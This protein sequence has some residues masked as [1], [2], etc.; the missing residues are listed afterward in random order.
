LIRINLVSCLR[1]SKTT[2]H[3][4]P[5]ILKQRKDL[6]KD[7][8][9]FHENVPFLLDDSL[10]PHSP[11]T[12]PEDDLDEECVDNNSSGLSECEEDADDDE[13]CDDEDAPLGSHPETAYLP[14]PS[15]LGPDHFKN[16]LI[17]A[18]AAEEVQLHINQASDA[19]QQLRLSLGLKSA[20]LRSTVSVAKSQYT[21]T[22]A[23]RAVNVVDVS[24]RRHAQQYRHAHQALLNLG[25][26]TSVMAN[27]PVLK[28]E[29]L[30]LSRDIME[31]NRFGQKSEHVTWIWRVK[32]QS[33]IGEDEWSTESE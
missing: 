14:L 12:M 33:M 31:E 18:L 29:D 11:Y 32:G 13:D 24:V 4:S 16:P 10:S 7:I 20:L 27:F 26:S 17:A 2:D 15:H 6:Q 19:L 1:N 25:A 9:L 30:K 23:W 21:K 28:K 8:K 22:R 5:K 3:N